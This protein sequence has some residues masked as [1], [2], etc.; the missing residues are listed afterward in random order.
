MWVC[1]FA[2]RGGCVSSVVLSVVVFV[3]AIMRSE[4]S[5][6]ERRAEKGVIREGRCE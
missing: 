4:V 1:G 6:L 5:A 3:V 2:F